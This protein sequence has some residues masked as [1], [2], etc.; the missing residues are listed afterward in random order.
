M[1]RGQK[2]TGPVSL[3]EES[4]QKAGLGQALPCLL[5][6]HQSTS[7]SLVLGCPAGIG[8]HFCGG[9]SDSPRSHRLASGRP[10]S[11]QEQT[12][13][14]PTSL[15]IHTKVPYPPT[16]TCNLLAS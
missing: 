13:P 9:D 15:H 4:H 12:S 6:T 7:G 14:N 16:T 5:A 3:R 8:C 10:R 11:P 1:A 2:S